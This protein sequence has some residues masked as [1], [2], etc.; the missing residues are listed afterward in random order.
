MG[1]FVNSESASDFA[2][3]CASIVNDKLGALTFANNAISYMGSCS[4]TDFEL[5]SNGDA[6]GAASQIATGVLNYLLGGVA[7]AIPGAPA[8][9]GTTVVSGQ[10]IASGMTGV[11]IPGLISYFSTGDNDKDSFENEFNSLLDDA[12]STIV[13]LHIELIP[14][15][16]GVVPTPFPG[17]AS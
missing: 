4:P 3:D 13:T 10:I 17:T 16:T 5:S 6:A 7:P 1:K 12:I 11:L 9:G 2:S 8:N 15:G 14:V